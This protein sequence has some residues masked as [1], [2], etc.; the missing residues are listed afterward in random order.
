MRLEKFYIVFVEGGACPSVRH[1]DYNAAK[2]EA[3]RITQKE[4]RPAYVMGVE[5]VA[6]KKLEPVIFV[7]EGA[8]CE[9][10][11]ILKEDPNISNL[12]MMQRLVND[13]AVANSMAQKNRPQSGF[14]YATSSSE[15]LFSL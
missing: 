6:Y 7:E 5:G 14:P 2:K 10:P 1:T 3:G 9:D 4:G 15:G 8:D 11:E 12:E 13:L